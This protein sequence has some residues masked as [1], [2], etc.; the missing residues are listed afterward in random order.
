MGRKC[1]IS[2]TFWARVCSNAEKCTG[3][4]WMRSRCCISELQWV[5]RDGPYDTG[6]RG[7]RVDA[8]Y[9]GGVR[10]PY[11]IRVTENAM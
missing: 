2:T 1:V 11:D 3:L 5:E 6:G 8:G 9:D 4:R 7:M 10:N